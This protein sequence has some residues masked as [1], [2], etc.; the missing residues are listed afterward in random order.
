MPN[1]DRDTERDR[2]WS[3]D[4]SAIKEGSVGRAEVFE[5][6]FSMTGNQAG[7]PS[8]GVVICQDKR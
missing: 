3:G 5:Q 4:L 7:V 8:R 6:P 1:P 2:G